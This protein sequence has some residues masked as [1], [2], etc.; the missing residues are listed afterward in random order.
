MGKL[1][2]RHVATIYEICEEGDLVYLVMEYMPGG[3]LSDRLHEQGAMSVLAA[4]QALSGAIEGVA[5]AHAAGLIHRDLKPSNLMLAGD[6]SVKV[7]DF[8][9]AKVAA[10]TTA[11]QIT[12][13]GAVLGTPYFMSPEQCESRPLDSRSDIYSLGATYYTLLTG[14]SPYADSGS[15]LQVLIRQCNGPIPDPR[16]NDPAIPPMCS[17]IVAAL[18][19]ERSSTPLSFGRGDAGG[20]AGRD[21]HGD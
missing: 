21:H 15:L 18:H 10:E 13:T 17:Q 14:T 20:L 3:S 6:G 5:A 7:T 2:H 8:G 11:Q 16:S 4:T 9:L 1:N 12:Q 19:G